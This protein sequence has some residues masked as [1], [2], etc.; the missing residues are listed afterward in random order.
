MRNFKKW[1]NSRVVI[2]LFLLTLL[3]SCTLSPS[4]G[5]GGI[6]IPIGLGVAALWTWLRYTGLTPFVKPPVPPVKGTKG[7][8]LYAVILT[9]AAIGV[10]IW[11]QMDA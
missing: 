11:M 8:L 2:L 7:T 3:Q 9:A 6:I 1:N 5:G 10:A 4:F